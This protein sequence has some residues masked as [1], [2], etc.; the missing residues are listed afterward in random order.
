MLVVRIFPEIFFYDQPCGCQALH[1]W[2]EISLRGRDI[3]S[4]KRALQ[5][6]RREPLAARATHAAT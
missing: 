4:D 5:Y 6:P 1:A 2:G 3:V